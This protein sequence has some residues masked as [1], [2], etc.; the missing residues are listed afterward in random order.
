[1]SLIN[2]IIPPQ[3]FELV[4]DRIAEI[5]T[6][7]V[8]NQFILTSNPDFD[9]DIWIERSIP[10]DK[11]ELPTINGNLATGSF[12]GHTQKTTDGTYTYFIDCFTKAVSTDDDKGDQL[13]SIKLQRLLGICRAILEDPKYKTLGF[14]PPSIF[15]RH[16]ESLSIAEPGKQDAASS[17]MGRL[18]FIVKVPET[19]ELITP[20]LLG[21]NDTRVKLF[22]TDRGYFYSVYA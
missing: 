2:G 1:M 15:N 19:V 7:E 11:E 17:V 16:C 6:T 14:S 5:L 4:R 8:A 22:E 13:A 12:S 9:L 21:R 20:I 18:S 3:N 10:F